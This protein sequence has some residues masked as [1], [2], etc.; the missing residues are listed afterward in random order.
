MQLISLI[1]LVWPWSALKFSAL[2]ITL[3]ALGIG[4]GMWTLAFNRIGNFNIRPEPKADATLIT[5]GPYRF[6]RHPM[7][8]ALLVFSSGIACWYSTWSKVACLV[9]LGVVLYVKSRVEETA[10]RRAF[11]EYKAYTQRTWRFIPFVL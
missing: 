6:I 4:L 2:G 7:Y 11:P 5:R 3:L 1:L 10:L 8:A 9:G